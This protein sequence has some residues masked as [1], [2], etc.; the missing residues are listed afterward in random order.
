MRRVILQPGEIFSNA[1]LKRTG[2]FNAPALA[3]ATDII[4]DVRE[5][6]D[7]ALRDYT[8]RFDGVRVDDSRWR[9]IMRSTSLAYAS[10]NVT[11]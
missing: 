5:R 8:E 11:R 7:A 9:S 10:S 6:G 2:A 1:H 4:E 3:A